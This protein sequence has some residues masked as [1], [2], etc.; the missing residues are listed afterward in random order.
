MRIPFTKWEL[1]RTRKVE[2]VPTNLLITITDECVER[3]KRDGAEKI[4]C[5]TIRYTPTMVRSGWQQGDGC[6]VETMP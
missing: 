4:G 5:V 1:R 3:L 6:Y 2:P